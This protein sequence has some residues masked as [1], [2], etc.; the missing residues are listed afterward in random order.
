MDY[1]LLP[2][3][4]NGIHPSVGWCCACVFG[5]SASLTA[6]SFASHHLI[7]PPSISPFLKPYSYNTR[8]QVCANRNIFEPVLSMQFR[9]KI[10]TIFTSETTSKF[11]H[12]KHNGCRHRKDFA[13]LHM[14]WCYA[15]LLDYAML[16][17]ILWG[18]DKQDY[19]C[20]ARV[21]TWL[22]WAEPLWW[23]LMSLKQVCLWIGFYIPFYVHM[24][25]LYHCSAGTWRCD[26]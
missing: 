23:R 16:Y 15:M 26:A 12:L 9:K 11:K 13:M 25:T 6:D 19:Y 1:G 2:C 3:L 14:L 17:A 10:Y 20:I 24:Q 22:S 8:V 18:L 4:H 5:V 7:F 21:L